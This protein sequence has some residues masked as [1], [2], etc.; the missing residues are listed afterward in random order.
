MS[1]PAPEVAPPDRY[2]PEFEVRIEGLEMDP[3]TKNDIID[4]KVNRDIDEMSGFDL[5]LNNW[6]DAHLRFKHSDSANF[7]LGG[8]VSVRLGYADKLLTVATG[9]ISTLSPKFTD[10]A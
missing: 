10:G 5:T 6:D 7:R 4:I 9:T 8:R 3:S 1:T 2:A